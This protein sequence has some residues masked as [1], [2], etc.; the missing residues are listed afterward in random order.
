MSKQELLNELKAERGIIITALN[1]SYIVGSGAWESQFRTYTL[2]EGIIDLEM[3]SSKIRYIIP[4]PAD[5]VPLYTSPDV[6]EEACFNLV[7]VAIRNAI[8]QYYEKIQSFCLGDGVKQPKWE[9]APWRPLARLARNSMSH[10]FILNFL[11]QKK[12]QL[13]NDVSFVFPSGR[14]IEIKNT[15]HGRP[16]TGD[17]L[18]LDAVIEL[19]D[20][21]K[22]F[23]EKDL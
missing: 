3:D 1:F 14:T 23:V 4:K 5:L 15:E 8:T 13:R 9:Q 21:M 2:S 19:L 16:I 12:Q 10:D 6:L 7:R 20:V 18:P 17:N 11:D 22:D